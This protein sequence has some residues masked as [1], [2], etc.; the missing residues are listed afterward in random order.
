[1]IEFD[2]IKKYLPKYLSESSEHNLFDNLRDFP[3]NIDTRLYASRN[4]DDKI[5]Y[6]GDGVE[7]FLIINLPDRTTKEAKVVILSN[8]CDIDISNV[9]L[10]SSSICY[11][12][13]LNLDKYVQKLESKSS[14]S[15]DRINQFKESVRKQ[16]ISQ[17]FFLPKGGKLLS[18]SFVFFDKINNCDTNSIKRE[19]LKERRLFTL[20]NYGFYLFLFKLSIHFTRIREEVD[21]I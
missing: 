6:Q 21:R 10:Y 15:V 7:G 11:S 9:R 20:S 12:P 2:E 4:L 1:M 16:R 14:A 8:T 19:T 3:Q 13:I 18:D 17:I 5:I